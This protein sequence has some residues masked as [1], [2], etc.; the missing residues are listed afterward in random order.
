MHALVTGAHF[1]P[2]RSLIAS[3]FVDAHASVEAIDAW[4][5]HRRNE[6]PRV[7]RELFLS[8]IHV[9]QCMKSPMLVIGAGQDKIIH[10]SVSPKIAAHYGAEFVL[11]PHLG[12]MCPFESGW[13]ETARYCE[14]WLSS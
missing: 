7:L 8:E 1:V 6:S 2:S 4:I 9:P 13:E 3:T 10:P 12:H 5:A 14:M 11:L